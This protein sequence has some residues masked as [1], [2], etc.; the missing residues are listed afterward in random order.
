MDTKQTLPEQTLPKRTRVAIITGAARGIGRAAALRLGLSGY[1]VGLIDVLAVELEAVGA[2]IRQAG[3]RAEAYVCSVTDADALTRAFGEHAQMAGAID[4]LV[5]CA[6][7]GL[8]AG[9]E[10]T[11]PAQWRRIL[12]INLTGTFLACRAILPIMR[13]QGAGQI[14]NVIS[15]AGKRTF[16]LQSAYCASKWG[17]VGFTRVLA[18]EVRAQGIRV[19]ALCPGAVDTPFWDSNEQGFDRTRMLQPEDVA[20]TILFLLSQPPGAVTEEMELMPSGGAF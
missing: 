7:I 9:V 3:G 5:N 15:I 11:S 8:F 17:A 2:E 10:D 19:M 4:V 18:Q 14:L 16:E 20:D 12:E 1:A 13:A 6:G